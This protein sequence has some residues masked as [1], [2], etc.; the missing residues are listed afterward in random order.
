MYD[1]EAGEP[2]PRKRLRAQDFLPPSGT[3]KEQVELQL[4]FL[5]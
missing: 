1:E 5:T 4:A 2:K 3:I